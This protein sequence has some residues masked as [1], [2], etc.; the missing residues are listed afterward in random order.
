M[1]LL[2][3]NLINNFDLYVVKNELINFLNKYNWYD[4]IV[5]Y[6]VKTPSRSFFI[7]TRITVYD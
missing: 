6:K 4:N 1:S 3:D 7:K 2:D 5:N